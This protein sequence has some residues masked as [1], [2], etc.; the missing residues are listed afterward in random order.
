MRDDLL[1]LDSHQHPF[2]VASG[3]FLPLGAHL[4][5]H[6]PGCHFS[7][8]SF[9]ATRVELCLFDDDEKAIACYTLDQKH[10]FLWSVFIEQVKAGQRYGYRVYGENNPLQGRLFDPDNLLIDPYAK[11]LSRVQHH[12]TKK[13]GCSNDKEIAK[14]FVVDD[15]FDW[16]EVKKPAIN[17]SKR[18]IYELHVKGFSVTNTALPMAKRGKY[19]GL[20]APE[21]IAHYKKLGITTLQIMPVFSFMSEA[22]LKKLTLTNY[23]GY[24]PICFFAPDCRYAQFDA[25]QEF[26]TMVKELHIAGIEVI[27]DVVFNHSA[28]SCDGGPILSL[29]GFANSE[30]YS[31][32]KKYDTQ[33]PDYFNYSNHSGC[34]NTLDVGHPWT[35]KLVMDALRY[36]SSEMQVDGFRFDLAAALAREEGEFNHDSA[37]FKAIQQDPLLSQVTLIAEPW[38]IGPGGYRLGG[39]PYQWLECNDRFR[40]TM[41]SFWRGDTGKVADVATRLLGSR[42]LFHQPQRGHAASINYICYHDGFTLHDLVSYEQRHNLANGEENRDGHGN[43][44]SAN[45]GVEGETKDKDYLRVREQ[46]KRNLIACL[47]LSQGTPHFLAG[48]EFGNSQAGNNNAYCQDN[49]LSWLDWKAIKRHQALFEFTTAMIALRQASKLFGNLSLMDNDS[50]AERVKWY[51]PDGHFM[52]NSD[53][54]ATNSQALCVALRETELVGEYWFLIFNA[55]TYHIHCKLPDLEKGLVWKTKLDTRCATGRLVEHQSTHREQITVHARS[56]KLLKCTRKIGTLTRYSP[57]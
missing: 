54:S 37:F 12:F 42:D 26:K 29:K 4:D 35:L 30:Y 38:D 16:G 17:A 2:R 19:L 20:S 25:L 21:S 28:E 34:G 22:R 11:A 23:W 48:D 51:H 14:S 15:Y 7:V 43:N 32:E 47:L 56:M 9:A 36:W 40:D 52:D 55:S 31:F 5:K 10:G 49:Q 57:V 6:K 33:L 46:Q 24:N 13:P 27:L 8:Y 53:W 41:R 1:K 50:D 44:L 45:Y 39:F 3:Q 18:I